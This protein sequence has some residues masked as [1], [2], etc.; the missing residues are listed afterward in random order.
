[1]N[2]LFRADIKT[3]QSLMARLSEISSQD[4]RSAAELLGGDPLERT[5]LLTSYP[6]KQKKTRRAFWYAVATPILLGGLFIFS[7]GDDPFSGLRSAS[8][9]SVQAYL[10][11][12][13]RT[14]QHGK[15]IASAKFNSAMEALEKKRFNE[16]AALFEELLSDRP[17]LAAQISV[18]HSQALSGQALLL[19]QKDPGRAET[20]LMQ[21]LQ[22]DQNNLRARFEL[23]SLYFSTRN[24]PK[25]IEAYQNVIKRDPDFHKAL[26][27][28]AFI[29]ASK[30]DYAMAEQMYQRVIDLSPPYADEAHFNLAV[31]QS[32]QGRK[33][34]SIANLEKALAMNPK[35][36]VARN[37][38]NRLRGSTRS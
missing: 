30:Q 10:A 8:V 26:F 24:Y 32:K 29:Y 38:L 11:M 5:R 7:I 34:Q 17:Q 20:L 36:Q 16:A 35:N 15:S 2:T 25:A 13:S 33:A 23:G 31:I 19:R 14:R 28:L 21:A 1:M 18:Y 22:M 9:P 27:N 3:G 37:Y 4:A 6:A 12:G